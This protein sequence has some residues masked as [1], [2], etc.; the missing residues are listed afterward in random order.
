MQLTYSSSRRIT[1]DAFIDVLHRSTLAQRRPVDDAPRI[2]GMLD[3]SNLLV[4]AWHEDKLIG[5]ARS[6]TDFH[7]ACYLSDLA[8]DEDYQCMGVGKALLR[9]T[10]NALQPDTKLI[11]LAAPAASTYYGKVGFFNHSGCWVLG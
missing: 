4:S 11:L 3:N 1:A 6:M 5:I 7:Y 10:Q 9:E 8:V 2:Q